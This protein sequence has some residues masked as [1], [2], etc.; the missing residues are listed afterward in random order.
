MT[1]LAAI[2][3]KLDQLLARCEPVERRY[4][5]VAAAAAY[6]GCIEKTIRRAL[7]A[8]ELQP[9]RPCRGRVVVDKRAIDA[10]LARTAGKRFRKGRGRN[11]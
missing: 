1:D 3:D 10:W 5:P 11:V 8:N 2:S 4:L 7:N 9:L 6:A